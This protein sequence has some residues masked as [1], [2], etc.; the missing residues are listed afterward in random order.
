MRKA[1]LALRTRGAAALFGASLAQ[2]PDFFVSQ[3]KRSHFPARKRFFWIPPGERLGGGGSLRKEGDG[4]Q[5]E[6][7]HG[8]EAEIHI[9]EITSEGMR[10]LHLCRECATRHT[11][12]GGVP[13]LSLE[14]LMGGAPDVFSA[15]NIF[16]E[17]PDEEERGE[18]P[19]PLQLPPGT[20][21]R[22][23]RCGTEVE[24]ALRLGHLGCADCFEVF[25]APLEDALR[26][27][28]GGTVHRGLCPSAMSGEVLEH[29]TTV[30]A[31]RRELDRAVALEAYER[32]AELRDQ[33][34]HLSAP[35]RVHE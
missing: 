3:E 12:P 22:C 15:K 28:H 34:Q 10:E 26:S 21:D 13:L 8:R 18:D 32:A 7:C 25:R 9:R 17:D 16:S 14:S 4:M 2:D 19:A 29:W 5:C 33:I 20:P 11:L 27:Y 31:L 1:S 30:R 23:P 6:E 24:E 35:E